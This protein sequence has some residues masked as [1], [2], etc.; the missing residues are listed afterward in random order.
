MEEKKTDSCPLRRITDK[1]FGGLNMSWPAVIAFAVG[2]AVVTAVFLIVPVFK[3]TSFARMGETFE[4]WIFFAVIIMSNCSKPLES[5]LKTFVFFLV[6][7]P[8]IYLL[9]VPFS[10][11]GWGLFGYYRFWFIL[12]LLTFPAAFVGWYITK[13]NW[14]SLLILAPVLCVLTFEYTGGFRDAAE[15]FPRMLVMALFCLAQVV[16]YLCAFTGNIWQKVIGFAV[17]LIVSLILVFA[18]P[19]VDLIA[20]QFLPDDPVLSENAFITV[21]DA[22]IADISV[23]ETGEDS[24]IRIHAERFGTTAFTVRDG[25]REYRYVIEIYRDDGGHTQIRITPED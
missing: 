12:T 15:H 23:A 5:A 8:L 16:L 2:T 6:S 25:E 4:A 7:Q 10:W 11:Q 24:M 19:Q 17:P 13:K 20:T 9:Q 1:L 3:G 18:G 14:L 21:E 22:E